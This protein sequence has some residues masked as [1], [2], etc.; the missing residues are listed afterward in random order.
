M[1][2]VLCKNSLCQKYRKIE[3]IIV[4]GVINLKQYLTVPIGILELN[5]IVFRNTY[6]FLDKYELSLR[7]FNSN[8]MPCE[9]I[10][11]NHDITRQ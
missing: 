7:F 11:K 8:F 10:I 5:K 9:R 1:K 4:I 2:C 3:I 6:P